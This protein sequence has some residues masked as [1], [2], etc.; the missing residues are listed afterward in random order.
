ML[1]NFF[2]NRTVYEIMWKNIVQS[3]RPQMTI[4]HSSIACWIP[5]AT[6]PHS[7]YVILIT[8]QLHQYLHE[9]TSTLSFMDIAC[10]VILSSH[11]RLGLP[12]ALFPSRIGIFIKKK[13]LQ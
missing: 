5:K 3:G 2:F 4:W 13:F 7:E 11:L 1:S 10:L 9:R 12:S 8:F 6:D